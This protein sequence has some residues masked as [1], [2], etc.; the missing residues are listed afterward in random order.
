MTPLIVKPRLTHE[1]LADLAM[2]RTTPFPVQKVVH[3]TTVGLPVLL[4]LQRDAL[5]AFRRQFGSL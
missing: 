4:P 1:Q 2:R 3:V 5:A